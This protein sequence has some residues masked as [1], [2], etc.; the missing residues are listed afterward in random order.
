MGKSI[1]S[2]SELADGENSIHLSAV[3]HN[4]HGGNSMSVDIQPTLLSSLNKKMVKGPAKPKA[5]FS[6]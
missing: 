2:I 1:H 5:R 6:S 4:S 3:E